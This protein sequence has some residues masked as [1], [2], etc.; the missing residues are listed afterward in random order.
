MKNFAAFLC[1][2]FPFLMCF[3]QN[4]L[5][6]S[7]FLAD[8][9][10]E[11]SVVFQKD[12]V[13][14]LKT[15]SYD[16][17]YI[18]KLEFRT[19]TND[20]DLRKQE[21]LIRISPN[22]LK[23]IHTQH[24]YQESVQYMTEMELKTAS[25]KALKG[26]YDL[27][28]NYIYLQDILGIKLKQKLLLK[29]KVTLLK[30]SIALANFDVLELIGAE[31]D[32]Q[33][34]LRDILDLKNTI[35]TLEKNIQ[36]KLIDS[37]F[38]QIDQDKLPTIANIRAIIDQSI[39]TY[40]LKHP[41]LEAQSARLYNNMLEYEWEAAKSKFSIG[42]IQAKFGHDPADNFKQ[43]I[44]FGIGFDIPLKSASRLDLNELRINILESESRFRNLKTNLEEASFAVQH[45]LQNLIKKYELVAEQV[46]VGQAEFAL[47]EYRKIAE[48]SPHAL[49][50]LR[51]NTLGIELI[52][53]QLQYQIMQSFI[54]YLDT[55]GLINKKP[56][57]NF[58]SKNMDP[59]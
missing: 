45:Q 7:T 51:E 32:A 56:Y 52:L 16:L 58:L 44:S 1:L 22:S 31:Y 3:G 10:K 2:I 47:Q 4:T 35:Q 11:E 36:R 39:A 26:R 50:K 8:A 20:F 33:E 29:D 54:D 55:T 37:Q 17:P 19:E 18:E 9:N 38:I 25:R 30:R 46:E 57:K 41:V 24:Q 59:F 48:A 40:L 42:Y 49:I 53:K 12:K 5:T 13:H 43:S 34:N 15:L 27:L 6:I 21:Y 23:N 14:F 28:V